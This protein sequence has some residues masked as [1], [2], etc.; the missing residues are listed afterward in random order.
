MYYR[1]KRYL[2]KFITQEL[3]V[4][5]SVSSKYVNYR[6]LKTVRINGLF[7]YIKKINILKIVFKIASGQIGYNSPYEKVV[8][9]PDCRI[10][11]TQLSIYMQK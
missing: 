10:T 6:S 4:I 7:N 9:E 11:F 8:Y 2:E 5:E 1:Y 3:S